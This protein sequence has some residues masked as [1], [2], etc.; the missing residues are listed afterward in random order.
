MRSRQTSVS[1]IVFELVQWYHLPLIWWHLASGQRVAVIRLS[2]SCSQHSW[3]LKQLRSG[4]LERL[5]LKEP[6]YIR[7]NLAGDYAFTACEKLYDR[8]TD[9]G[10]VQNLVRL[11][12]SDRVHL[13]YKKGLLEDLVDVFQLELLFRKLAETIGPGKEIRVVPSRLSSGWKH[14]QFSRM[15]PELNAAGTPRVPYW[16]EVLGAM[17]TFLRKLMWSAF[18]LYSI[19]VAAFRYWTAVVKRRP[20]RDRRAHA[21]ALRSPLRE[22]AN[23]IR[24]VDFLLDGNGL[25]RDN[26][27]FVPIAQATKE[28]AELFV[29]EGYHL[30]DLKGAPLAREVVRLFG[31][32]LLV[33]VQSLLKTE[34]LA[35]S[36]AC[37]LSEYGTWTGFTCR[38]EIKNFITYCDFGIR[39]IGRNILLNQQG[40]TTWHYTDT[41]NTAA[42]FRPEN[43]R[44][45][46]QDYW[47]YMMYDKFVSWSPWFSRFHQG[48]HQM[49]GQYVNVGVLWAE[50]VRLYREGALRS[51]L[52]KNLEAKG[53][54]PGQQ[55][56]SVFDSSYHDETLTTYKDGIEFLKGVERLLQDLPE[57]FLVLKEKKPRSLLSLFSYDPSE[58]QEMTAILN[59]LDAHQRCYLPGHTG[60][61]SEIIAHSD[62]VLCYP[63]TST[64]IE[65]LAS[66]VM[67]LYYDPTAKFCKTEY[68]RIPSLVVHDYTHLRRRIE[69]VL[70]RLNRNDYDR[71]FD[72]YVKGDLEPYMDGRAIT[73][74]RTLLAEEVSGLK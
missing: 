48:H 43:G 60:I 4:R 27:V 9:L 10:P 28:V 54:R 13:A 58:L 67:A 72:Q 6:L 44:R 63:F 35:R 17:N 64:G 12:S 56:V 36:S 5:E 16:D 26:T 22:M 33:V 20:P 30:A 32:G 66:G 61:A 51:D 42:A 1:L 57:L 37:M 3:L 29:K 71:F 73:R 2:R 49:I 62:L 19:L 68:A 52:L 24:G 21:I 11:Y 14:R 25:R 41:V 46:R 23:R 40:V 34:W 39:H 31:Y 38:Y 18:G 50:H 65:A 74:F 69:E 55:L 70:F 59:R 45:Y 8:Y 15:L 47:G 7:P 53:Y